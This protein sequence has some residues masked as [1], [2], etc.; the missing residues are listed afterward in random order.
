M[1][2]LASKSKQRERETVCRMC[3]LPQESA[4]FACALEL[5]GH[6]I[7][8]NGAVWCPMVGFRIS[9]VHSSGFESAF[10]VFITTRKAKPFYC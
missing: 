5:G 6:E 4:W 7:T 8:S 2:I 10:P 1:N 3:S 9:G